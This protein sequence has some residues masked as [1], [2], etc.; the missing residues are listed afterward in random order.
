MEDIQN[1]LEHF[2]NDYKDDTLK[3]INKT[4]LRNDFVC[5]S[6]FELIWCN[7]IPSQQASCAIFVCEFIYSQADTTVVKCINFCNP[8]TH[9]AMVFPRRRGNSAIYP[10]NK[11]QFTSLT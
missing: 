2:A 10:V 3:C 11:I 7:V 1:K 4:R 9:L 8:S 6:K 5:I